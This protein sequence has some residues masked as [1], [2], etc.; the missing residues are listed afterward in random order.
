MNFYIFFFLQTTQNNKE[1]L[2][3]IPHPL[4]NYFVGLEKPTS[5]SG[6]NLYI[7]KIPGNLRTHN[8]NTIKKVHRNF[9]FR[10]SISYPSSTFIPLRNSVP[11]LFSL[12]K[13]KWKLSVPVQFLLI[14]SLNAIA[15]E[16]LLHKVTQHCSKQPQG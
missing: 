14:S 4:E 16:I 6:L 15:T 10:F 3:S 12:K 5:I 1:I 11:L 9:I 13:H 2:L 7:K 8:S